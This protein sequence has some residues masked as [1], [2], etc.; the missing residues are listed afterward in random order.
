MSENAGPESKRNYVRMKADSLVLRYRILDEASLPAAREQVLSRVVSNEDLAI[1]TDK[2]WHG[3][4][5][6]EAVNQQF[7]QTSRFLEQLDSK[8]D[9]VI[10]RL[11]GT[12]EKD[13]QQMHPLSLID[14]SGAGLAF[15]DREKLAE[16]SLVHLHIQFSRFPLREIEAVG[17]V[18][19]QQQVADE[20]GRNWEMGVQFDTILQDDRER[21]FR[22]ISRV[23]RQELRRRKEHRDEQD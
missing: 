1:E 15:R 6:R 8:L 11:D 19:W 7:E 16:N 20:S 4:D 17:K 18:V 9:Y 22:F 10:A 12:I 3:T 13:E 5:L 23:E 21:I 14:I 2:L